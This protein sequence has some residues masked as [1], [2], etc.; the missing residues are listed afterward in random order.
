MAKGKVKTNAFMCGCCKQGFNSEQA[1]TNHIR[2][3]HSGKATRIYTPL[4]LIDLRDEREPS[5]A[6]LTIEAEMNK[7]MGLPY[8]AWLLGE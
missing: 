3:A 2:A 8:E 7:N 5:I 4:K 1:V 6:E